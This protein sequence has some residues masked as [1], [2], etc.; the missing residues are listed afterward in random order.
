MFAMIYAITNT[1]K[2][3]AGQV[4]VQLESLQPAY[5]GCVVVVDDTVFAFG[6]LMSKP[7]LLKSFLPLDIVYESSRP[8]LCCLFHDLS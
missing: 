5:L 8:G 2:P 6:G 4:M 3:I 7:A 1:E